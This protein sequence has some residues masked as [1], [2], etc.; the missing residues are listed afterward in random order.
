MRCNEIPGVQ[1]V[2]HAEATL[3]ASGRNADRSD[4]RYFSAD[5]PARV[6]PRVMDV[7]VASDYI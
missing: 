1:G 7:E 3:L 2:E 5:G 6:C 4:A